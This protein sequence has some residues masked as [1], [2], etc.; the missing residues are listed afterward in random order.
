MVMS[1]PTPHPIAQ[2]VASHVAD[3]SQP[4]ML[5]V[6][7]FVV[8]GGDEAFLAAFADAIRETLPEK[9]CLRYEMN[10]A[11]GVNGEYLLYERWASL[12]ELE[13]HLAAPHIATLGQKTG[14]LRAKPAELVVASCIS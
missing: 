5:L 12:P 8:D 2:F 10:K 6:R 13:A 11:L 9:G 3:P 7:F 1:Q 4:F 14:S